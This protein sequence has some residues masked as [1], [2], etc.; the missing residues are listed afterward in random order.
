MILARRGFVTSPATARIAVA[1]A[2]IN[3]D[4]I[5]TFSACLIN[6]IV[7]LLYFA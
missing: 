4:M 7:K 2:M 6:E 3:D 1:H 5:I